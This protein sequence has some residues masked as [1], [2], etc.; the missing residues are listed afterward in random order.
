MLSAGVTS[1]LGLLYW[2]LAAHFYPPRVVGLNSEMISAM[3]FLSGVA[4]LNLSGAFTRF[5][6]RAAGTTGR[7]I[8]YSYLAATIA[9]LV[10]AGIFLLGVGVWA[11]SLAFLRSN[12]PF[13]LWFVVATTAWGIFALQDMALTGM[14]Q[15][16]WV[17]IENT[18]FGL[19]KIALLI[20]VAGLSPAFGIFASWTVPTVASLL[21]VNLLIF[22]YLVRRH[23]RSSLLETLP[24]GPRHV[25]R[26][27]AADYVGS[28]FSLA[29]SMLLP[30]IVTHELGAEATA[31]FYLAWLITNSLQLAS[32]SMMASLTVEGAMD[33]AGFPALAQ[34]AIKNTA[35]LLIPAIVVLLV[36]A[37]FILRL[38][39]NAYAAQGSTL[40]RLLALAALP[41]LINLLYSSAARVRRRTGRILVVEGA[42][43][44]QLLGLGSFLLHRYGI[45]GI[46]VA[47]VISQSTVAA[48][49][50][51][52]ELRPLVGVV[53]RPRRKFA[54]EIISWK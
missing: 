10:V 50:L 27:V 48:G 42:I 30:I 7:L 9:A 24:V 20:A 52:T 25:V 5:I 15:A 17:P 43:C 2:V 37:P 49:V 33:H 29:A 16:A 51:L 18:L 45:T 40:L 47:A 3:L 4:Q 14:R 32:H 13:G 23:R 6:P 21:P 12:L 38:F 44:L 22:L 54:Q 34:R 41:N 19:V 11:P 1:G 26:F 8:G 28:L 35:R 36:A 31:F 39:G 53:L 46:G